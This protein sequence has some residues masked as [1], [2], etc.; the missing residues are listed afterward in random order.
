[1]LAKIRSLA[2]TIDRRQLRLVTSLSVSQLIGWGTLYYSFS[3][4]VDPLHSTFGWSTSEINTALTIGFVTWASAAP[5]VGSA[6]DRY[7]GSMV[8]SFGSAMGIISLLVWAFSTSLY[9]LYGAWFLMGIAMASALYKPAFYVLTMAYPD[10]YK[11]VIT[12]LTLAGG[13]ASTVFIPLIELAITSIGWHYSLLAMAGCNLFMALPIHI[14]KLPNNKNRNQKNTRKQKILD[15]DLFKEKEFKIQTFWGLNLWFVILNSVTTS[16]TFLFIPLLSEIGTA[17]GTIILSFSMIGPMQVV[18][19]FIMMWFDENLHALK[20][21]TLITFLAPIG[22]GF[23]VLF[24]QSLIAL[25]LFAIFFG[26]AKGIMT[27]IKGT[28]V[29]EQM[30]FSVYAR[31]NGWLSLFS[32]LSKAITPTAV[33]GFWAFMGDPVLTL[34]FIGFLGVLAPLGIWLIKNDTN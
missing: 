7:G 4:F 13:F 31:T 29:A 21:G 2:Q 34:A 1:M 25:M 28:I 11:K 18:G 9:M 26:T 20:I 3:L 15:F 8:M 27:I 19:R 14:W 10:Q 5:F 12:W 17:Q 32:M 24:P 16:I 22:I 23:A 30:D 6:L 33:A